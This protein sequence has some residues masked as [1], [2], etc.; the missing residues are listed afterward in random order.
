VSVTDPIGTPVAQ[1][2]LT[3][4]TA[5]LGQLASPP[6]YIQMRVGQETGPLL[7]ANVDECCA[8]LAWVRIANIYPSWNS[9]PAAD[10]DWLLSS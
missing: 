8:G 2:L 6:K 1:E 7:G 10:N 5:Q 3:C 4:F 9:F